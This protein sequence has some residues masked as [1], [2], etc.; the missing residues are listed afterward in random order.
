MYTNGSRKK[1]SFFSVP[2]TKALT[3]T[4]LGLMA[5]ETWGNKKKTLKKRFFYLSGTAF[6][7]T[8]F[9][10][11][12]SGRATIKRFFLRLPLIELIFSIIH[13]FIPVFR[14]F[15]FLP[16]SYNF[17]CIQ[18]NL[19]KWD[20]IS[21]FAKN[22]EFCDLTLLNMLKNRKWIRKIFFITLFKPIFTSSP[23]MYYSIFFCVIL[24]ETEIFIFYFLLNINLNVPY[25][26]LGQR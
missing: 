9:F 4:P 8:A 13:F 18:S 24:T 16:K 23:E 14:S 6:N 25:R 3:P 10:Y 17:V 2:V 1:N 19:P 5:V 20:E 15:C 11:I 12:L 7:P 21:Y 26:R 22:P